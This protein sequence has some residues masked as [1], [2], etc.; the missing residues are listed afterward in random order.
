MDKLLLTR[1]EAAVALGL[2]TRAIDYL[3]HQGRLPSRKLGKRRLI[4]VSAVEAFARRDHARISPEAE[5]K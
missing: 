1:A 4:P 5:K 3:V 2:S